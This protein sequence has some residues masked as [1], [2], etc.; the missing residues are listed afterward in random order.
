[1]AQYI[2]LSLIAKQ[3][4][5]LIFLCIVAMFVLIIKSKIHQMVSNKSK[6]SVSNEKDDIHQTQSSQQELK[7]K[8]ISDK[9]PVLQQKLSQEKKD[10]EYLS[11]TQQINS[12]KQKLEQLQQEN[13]SLHKINQSLQ[14]NIKDHTNYDERYNVSENHVKPK[15]G[16]VSHDQAVLKEKYRKLESE[17]NKLQ[18]ENDRLSSQLKEYQHR[19]KSYTKQI[20]SLKEKLK[21]QQTR[22][23][24]IEAQQ[25]DHTEN[26]PVSQKLNN[27]NL[28]LARDNHVDDH[29]DDEKESYSVNGMVLSEFVVGTM[30]KWVKEWKPIIK[31]MKIKLQRDEGDKIR[32]VCDDEHSEKLILNIMIDCNTANV[33][34]IKPKQ[35]QWKAIDLMENDTENLCTFAI[36]FSDS[37]GADEFIKLMKHTNCN[38]TI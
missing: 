19:E 16:L 29:N 2:F 36:K 26:V 21:L 13:Q 15:N 18:I 34:K 24:S 31:K 27:K 23:D 8:Q 32:I 20:Q 9:S 12:M 25:L 1:M 10:D 22:C 30:Y 33:K 17:K 35:V 5:Y 4:N 11:L 7:S 6:S 38:L 14:Q 37:E 28:C 3:S